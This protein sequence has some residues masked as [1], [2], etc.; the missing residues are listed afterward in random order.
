MDHFVNRKGYAYS[1]I[2]YIQTHILYI[3]SWT[4]HFFTPLKDIS[5]IHSH[6]F[7]QFNFVVVI[8]FTQENKIICVLWEHLSRTVRIF[9]LT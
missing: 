8:R 3:Q 1:M 4:K 6:P 2:D 5:F 7:S 9:W